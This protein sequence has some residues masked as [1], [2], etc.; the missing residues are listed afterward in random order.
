MAR[1]ILLSL[2]WGSATLKLLYFDQVAKKRVTNA[3]R[4]LISIQVL[5]GIDF[6]LPSA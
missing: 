4:F 6:G 3:T 1:Q 2:F 5:A